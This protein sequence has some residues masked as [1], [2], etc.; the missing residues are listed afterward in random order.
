MSGE[1]KADAG[2]AEIEL[3]RSLL[4]RGSEAAGVDTTIPVIDMSQSDEVVAAEMWDAASNVGFFTV[5]GHGIAQDVI[6]QSFGVAQEFFSLEREEKEAASPFAQQLN[7]GYEFMTQVRPSTGTADQKESLQITARQGCMDGRWPSSPANFEEV[8]KTM[9]ANCNALVGRI[10]TLLESKACPDLAPGTLARA[11]TLWGEDGQCTLRYLHYP[12]MD[13][14]TLEKLTGGNGPVHWRA[15][16][17][18][19][20]DCITLLFQRLGQ[21]GLECSANPRDL[22]K[23]QGWSAV[24]PAEGGIAINI[25][26]MLS[27]WSDGRLFSNLHRV[28]MPTKEECTPPSSRYSIAFFAQ[29]DK[30]TIISSQDSEPIT[31]GD[32]ILSRIRSNFA[33][34]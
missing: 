22:S 3:E 12:P 26:D 32:Y 2:A 30:S 11:H 9:A 16:P 13:V 15:G 29:A 10:L 7:S 21:A 6:E 5:V 4:A 17:H 31:A 25:G 34:K 8:S 20:W 1:A 23:P 33:K 24:P 19:D 14:D 28:R 27:R 18:T